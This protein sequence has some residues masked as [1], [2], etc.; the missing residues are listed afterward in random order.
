[1]IFTDRNGNEIHDI[2]AEHKIVTTGMDN[3]TGNDTGDTD[4]E[5]QGIMGDDQPEITLESEET[6]PQ[7]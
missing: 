2:D 4:N 1:L 3:D 6:N 5:H 7:I